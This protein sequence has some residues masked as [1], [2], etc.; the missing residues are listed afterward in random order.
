MYANCKRRYNIF[1]NIIIIRVLRC[2]I[3]IYIKFSDKFMCFKIRKIRLKLYLCGKYRE[4]FWIFQVEQ[5]DNDVKTV[6]SG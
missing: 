2:L 5:S 6:G 4:I 3:I 1:L